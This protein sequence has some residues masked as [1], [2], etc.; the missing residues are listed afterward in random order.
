MTVVAEE[1][2]YTRMGGEP[3]LR[4]VID[5]FVDRAFDDIMIGFM[6]RNADRARIKE[7]EFQHASEFLGGPHAYQ[8]RPLRTAHA[9]HLIMG[10]QFARRLQLLRQV[11]AAHSVPQDVQAAFLAHNEG[12]R[13]QITSQANGTCL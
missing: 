10:G 13:D 6:F 5:D 2:L 4:A 3:A 9:R 11:F 12:L 7:L 8:G 1:S